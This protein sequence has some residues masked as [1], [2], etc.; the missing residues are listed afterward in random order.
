MP[1]FSR[2]LVRLLAVAAAA[3]PLF[4]QSAIVTV[5]SMSRD[6]GSNVIVD[7]LNDRQWL[8]F[9]V[10]KGLSYEQT[11]VAIGV[12]GQ[13]AGYSIAHKADAQKFVDALLGANAC[14][15]SDYAVCAYGISFDI[16][17]IT[18]E[19]YSNYPGTGYD[20]DYAWFLS[21]S[22]YAAVGYIQIL[23][24][25]YNAPN[26]QI[27]KDNEWGA[28]ANADT[29]SSIGSTSIYPIGWMLYRDM[30]QSVPEPG[31]LSLAGLGLFAA[32]LARRR[33]AR[34]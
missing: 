10:T 23:T 12:G 8:G 25:Y 11:L 20:F 22:V 34:Q 16:E 32:A 29:Y 33:R 9:D 21:D 14:S 27:L 1:S 17:K 26:S 19:D 30:P 31:T 5:G 13:F 6:T 15:S 24:D 4:A 28:I 3:T 2:L 18:G 7:T